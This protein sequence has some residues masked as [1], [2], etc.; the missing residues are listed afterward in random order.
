MVKTPSCCYGLLFHHTLSCQSKGSRGGYALRGCSS[1]A[2][3]PQLNILS[4]ESGPR[5]SDILTWAWGSREWRLDPPR[6]HALRENIIM[7]TYIRARVSQ[8]VYL[9]GEGGMRGGWV[10]RVR[11]IGDI[12][13]KALNMGHNCERTVL[14]LYIYASTCAAK[15]RKQ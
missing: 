7:R 4:A 11:M 6:C 2:R 5:R 12:V 8:R 14:L 15:R 1:P 9:K 13:Q 10:R 3:W